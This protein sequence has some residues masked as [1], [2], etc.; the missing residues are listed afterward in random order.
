MTTGDQPRHPELGDWGR[1]RTAWE[2][3][4]LVQSWRGFLGAPQRWLRHL[5]EDDDVQR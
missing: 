4:D 5:L 1:R 2:D 3:L